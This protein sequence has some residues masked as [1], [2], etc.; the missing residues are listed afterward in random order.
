MPLNENERAVLKS[1]R[2]AASREWKSAIDEWV[3]QPEGR[4]ARLERRFDSLEQRI[5]RLEQLRAERVDLDEMER[6]AAEL[7]GGTGGDP[8]LRKREELTAKFNRVCAFRSVTNE[9]RDRTHVTWGNLRAVKDIA[10]PMRALARFG[11][12]PLPL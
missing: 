7:G 8:T 2:E 6:A 4:V 5:A 3:S 9:Q 1:V 11:R 12:P 10:E